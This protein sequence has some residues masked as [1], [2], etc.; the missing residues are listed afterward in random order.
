MDGLLKAVTPEERWEA[1]VNFH[2]R[3]TEFWRDR[4]SASQRINGYLE[5]Q[6]RGLR[7]EVEQLKQPWYKRLKAANKQESSKKTIK[8]EQQ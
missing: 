4:W 7:K 5:E 3:Q 6:I 2:K 1:L 8:G